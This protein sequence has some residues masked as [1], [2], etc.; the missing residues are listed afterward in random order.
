M[1][2]TLSLAEDR[3]VERLRGVCIFRVAQLQSEGVGTRAL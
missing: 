2:Q 3:I 1:L